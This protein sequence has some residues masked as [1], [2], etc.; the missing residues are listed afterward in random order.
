MGSW[1]PL[2]GHGIFWLGLLV[3][4]ILYAVKRKWYPVMYLISISLYIFTIGFTI[5]VFNIPK[6]GILG[7]LALSALIMIGT[8]YYLSKKFGK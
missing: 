6:N 5:D 1:Y 4:I 3:A 7:L 8:G 2:L